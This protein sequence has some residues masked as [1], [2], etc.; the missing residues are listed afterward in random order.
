VLD[1]II[2]GRPIHIEGGDY[3]ATQLLQRGA[4][5]KQENV[6]RIR[7][8]RQEGRG[9]PLLTCAGE[10]RGTPCS[11][12][13]SWARVDATATAQVDPRQHQ[14]WTNLDS[15][16]KYC[17]DILRTKPGVLCASLTADASGAEHDRFRSVVVRAGF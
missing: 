2:G 6:P 14:V 5:F 8:Q 13:R 3:E 17:L 1:E 7:S 9:T 4:I 12:A 16:I 11:Y 10:W 15:E